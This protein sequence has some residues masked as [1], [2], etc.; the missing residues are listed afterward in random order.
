M[1][2]PFSIS[3]MLQGITAIMAVT[4]VILCGASAKGAFDRR[5]IDEKALRVINA[6]RHLFNAMQE[7][8]LERGGL[9]G[10]L[11]TPTP[12]P[13]ASFRSVLEAR[14]LSNRD[15]DTALTDLAANDPSPETRAQLALIRA[16]RA[17]YV[18]VQ[19]Q[20]TAALHRPM[21][22]RP[23]DLEAR[24]TAADDALVATAG[25]VA[26]RLGAEAGAGDPF[27]SEMMR[28]KQL[29]WR[30]RDAAGANDGLLAQALGRGTRL[31]PDDEVALARQA[32]RA[33]QAWEAVR[34]EA[35]A[36]SVPAGLR[37]AVERADRVYYRDF[38][39]VRQTAY[40]DLA[41]GR[42]VGIAHAEIVR[43]DQAG[44]AALM[45]VASTAFD[46]SEA[47]AKDALAGA[48]RD[49]AL[50]AALMLLA[51]GLGVSAVIFI[52]VRIVGPIARVT[53][54]MG[55][56]AG[57]DL[58]GE[59]PYQDRRDEIGALARA[60]SVFRRN[61]LEKRRVE[62]ELVASRIAVEAAEAASRLKSQFLAN[63]SHEI[64]T[65]LNAVIGMAQVM[66]RE[67]LTPVQA[68]RLAAIRDSGHALLQILNDVLDLSKIEAGEL[69]LVEADFD[70][71]DLV[72]RTRAAFSGAAAAKG[73]I[74]SAQ[75]A[76]GADGCW[77]GDAARLRQILSNLISNAIKFTD[78][79]R[80]T[81]VVERQPDGLMFSVRDTGIGISP[82]ALP[83][84]FSKF[85]QVDDSNTRRFGGTGL[86]L[87]ISRELAQMM[88]GD[89]E[90]ESHSGAGSTFR[91]T[92][93]LTRV[94]DAREPDHAETSSAAGPAVRERPLRVLAAEDNPTNR[95][96]L[97]AL[98]RP[99]G[100]ELTIVE[101][102]QAAIDHWMSEPCDMILMDIQMPRMS[103][104]AAAE[105][106]RAAE[107]ARGARPTPI[108]A[109]SANAMNHQV[110]SYLAAGMTAHVAKP[111][112]VAV[113]YRTI[114]E[115]MAAAESAPE[116]APESSPESSPASSPES[117]QLE[118]DVA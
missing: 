102:G 97:A 112:E 15:L 84:L 50:A 94:G 78:R 105:V 43:R 74:M 70:V 7:I 77:R 103:G 107:R 92:I 66:E 48:D 29:V 104:L 57:G 28:T 56:V 117:S 51:I 19:A 17:D 35:R 68:E 65:P 89:I 80:V 110:N 33:D 114:D 41:A 27:I 47:R 76:P 44:L 10:A 42:A 116:S 23:V 64:R 46:L 63:M 32:G 73:L 22:E 59:I 2:R 25:G 75:V 83:R 55:E 113:L 91:L 4:L 111:I 60:L 115:V 18:T 49:A 36:P 5:Q 30:A 100:V 14:T 79:G 108:V 71:A 86:G 99:L 61:A 95:K 54:E 34:E 6:S 62:D 37:A 24:W 12:F 13:A 72:E 58:E 3:V 81:L 26:R 1:S 9:D 21:S 8:R 38:E 90:V 88:G 109:L 96:V 16:R 31:T 40:R 98:L 85:S 52:N 53:V 101:D 39:S 67:E 20:V 82:K 11:V 106:I 69:E 118:T 93:P 87:A 45:T